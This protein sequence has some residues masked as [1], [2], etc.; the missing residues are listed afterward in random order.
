MTG[1]KPR[2]ELHFHAGVQSAVDHNTLKTSVE[3]HLRRSLFKPLDQLP[4]DFAQFTGRQAE[5]EYVT[6]ILQNYNKLAILTGVAGVGKSALSI[7]AAYQLKPDFPDAQ[8]YVNLRGTESQP[9][10]PLQVLAGF[11]RALAG[12]DL[13]MPETIT[14]R[15]NL[16]RSLLSNQRAIIILDNAQNEAQIQPLLP[17]NA[18]C[19][20][21]ITT[22]QEIINL[23]GA[24]TLEVEAMKELDA[25]NLFEYWIGSDRLL[26][27]PASAQHIIDLCSQL[28]LAICLI[29]A[30]I[31]NKPEW[32]LADI[33]QRLSD[34]RQRLLSLRVSDLAI[35]I[36]IAL[37]YQELDNITAQLFRL[38]GLITGTTFSGELAITLL[39]SKPEVAKAS[40]KQ[41]VDVQLIE[42]AGEGRYRFHD[43]VRLFAKGQLAQEVR[44]AARQAARLRL[45]RWYLETSQL[46]DLVIN[47]DNDHKLAQVW[48]SQEARENVFLALNWFELEQTNL[49]AALKWA[50]QVKA[51]EIVAPLVTNLVNFFKAY[52][53]WDDWQ[54]THEFALEAAR[55]LEQLNENYLLDNSGVRCQKAQILA[56]LGNVYSLQNDWQKASAAYQ[57]SMSLYEELENPLAVAKM[58]GNLA[59]VD[60]RQ[61]NWEQANG[62]YQH[63]LKMFSQLNDSDAEGQTL[64]NFGIFWEQ[65]NQAEKAAVLWQEA[66][67]KLPSDLPR[68]KRIEEWLNS[69]KPAF[70]EVPNQVMPE[71][72]QPPN[73]ME[74]PTQ[75]TTQP[76][77]T[78]VVGAMIVIA[79]AFFLV[80]IM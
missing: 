42:I 41:L 61:G 75:A 44:Q 57:A 74:V 35:R 25:V 19:A 27:E 24:T 58:L 11:V 43:L 30:T 62:R 68:A 56:N 64:A 63:S 70:V 71:T 69:I 38:L 60:Y 21:I 51:W 26:T 47:P 37:S 8:L 2:Y 18:N 50:H 55:T 9:L 52:G 40:I 48:N 10:E 72:T 67:T 13:P 3:D 5:L 76:K 17:E 14:Q 73:L 59:N 45:S 1:D 78:T 6:N 28:P 12:N 65:Q 66:L 32:R 20:V 46:M 53:C 31:K 15:T 4:P 79:I 34:E 23:E 49:L 39:E 22:R 7:H 77:L 16:Y 80:F 54:Q 36:S 33:A 29:G